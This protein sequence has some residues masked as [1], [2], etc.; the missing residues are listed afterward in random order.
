MVD[1]YF[2]IGASMNFADFA[3][4]KKYI[5]PYKQRLFLIS[6]LAII[7]AFFEAINLGSLVP[8][9][10]LMSGENQP[11]GTLWT[12]L[13]NV[14]SLIGIELTFL[15]LLAV[16]TVI[17]IVGQVFLY[18][19]KRLQ[20]G[21]WFGFSSDLKKRI[22][23]NILRADMKFLYSQKSGQFN[24]SLTRESE[25]AATSVFALTEIVTYI[26]FIIV[27]SAMLLYISL[28]MTIICLVL[29]AMTT[30]FLNF[31]ILQSKILA[32]KMVDTNTRLNEFITS[33]N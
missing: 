13:E 31:L 16:M 3:L 21:L 22:F 30:Y 12:L 32:D 28:E 7:C 29:A 20:V 2:H 33:L 14:F 19:K 8:L 6:C 24:T 5:A 18:Q 10:Q 23:H 26:F 4:L 15:N 11:G 17:F 1:S 27:Y 9:L 25:Y